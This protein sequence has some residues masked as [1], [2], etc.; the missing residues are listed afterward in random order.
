MTCVR[1]QLRGRLTAR[2]V[3]RPPAL[4]ASH[5]RPPTRRP[6][7]STAPAGRT[8]DAAVRPR[9][10]GT[11]MAS[12][13]A[14]AEVSGR[15]CGRTAPVAHRLSGVAVPAGHRSCWPYLRGPWPAVAAV[16]GPVRLRAAP[17]AMSAAAAAGT[18]GL[19]AGGCIRS[20]AGHPSGR[21]TAAD[22]RMAIDTSLATCA[23]HRPSGGRSFRTQR[24]VNP[25]IAP[26]RHNFLYPSSSHRRGAVPVGHGY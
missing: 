21:Q 24:T 16:P 3:P 12:R 9:V 23:E 15:V 20:A 5:Q 6:F 19:H 14:I 7:P 26:A 25:P 17:V 10:S 4:A 8:P 1:D 22:S 11:W 18:T 2:L 13:T